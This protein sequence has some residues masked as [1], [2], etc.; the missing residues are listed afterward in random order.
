M[1]ETSYPLTPGLLGPIFAEAGSGERAMRE[2]LFLTFN[3]DLGFFEDRLLG[4]LRETGAAV[5]VVADA[6]VF[7]PDTR[8]VR[9]AGRGYTF[10][11]AHHSAAFHPKLT[12][13][14][15][16]Q[17]ALIG[18][19][20]GNLT[21]GGWHANREILTTIE[22]SRSDG[23][24]RIVTDVIA[25]M[26]E[27][28]QVITIGPLA[29]DGIERTAD[30]LATLAATSKPIDTG[31]RLVHSLGTPIID[32]LPNGE[33]SSLELAAPFHDEHGRALDALIQRYQPSEITV[34]AQSGQA[35]MTPSALQASAG[36]T[37]LH[38]V[39]PDA[40]PA[41]SRYRHGKILTALD[42]DGTVAWSL[43]GSP[44]LTTAALLRT[45]KSTPTGNCELGIVTYD[46][47]RLLPTPTVPVTDVVSLH[48]VLPPSAPSEGAAVGLA[49]GISEARSTIDGLVV[50]L[51]HAT[52]VDLTI[53]VSPYL[54]APE[55]FEP[56]GVIPVGSIQATF[57]GVYD[58]GTRVRAGT[59]M[60]FVADPDLV[61]LRLR[62]SSASGGGGNVTHAELFADPARA[63]KWYQALTALTLAHQQPTTTIGGTS[64]AS[65]P[66]QPGAWKTLEDEADWN[67]YA[68]AAQNMLGLPIFLLA[69]GSAAATIKSTVVGG[70]L[71][72]N[73]P[74]W[75]DR[76]D[77]TAD[78]FE[79]EQTAE[80][81]VDDPTLVPTAPAP[82]SNW[83][84]G[85]Y[86]KWIT[87]LTEIMTQLGPIERIAATQLVLVSTGAGCW[88]GEVGTHGWFDPLIAALRALVREDWPTQLQDQA[89]GLLAVGL[90]RLRL[91]TPGNDRGREAEALRAL[92]SKA[93][94]MMKHVPADTIEAQLPLIDGSRIL[95]AQPDDVLDSIHML[96]VADANEALL[97]RLGRLLPELD[98][99]WSGPAQLHA[100]GRTSNPIQ[101]AGRIFDL[102]EDDRHLAVYVV[103]E[104]DQWALMVSSADRVLLVD[105]RKAPIMYTTH[106]RDGVTTP[107]AL[108][109][110][111]ETRQRTRVSEL[112]FG[113]PGEAEFSVVA[114]V[115]IGQLP[116]SPTVR[117]AL[118]R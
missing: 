117:L 15:G 21:I 118:T 71:P 62:P 101:T 4:K 13:L 59:S 50:V 52:Q 12:V 48:H 116:I 106:R 113:K 41:A 90:Y 36:S 16:P 66:H 31:H 29:R 77:D 89:A 104:K 1:P 44:N 105:G 75:E 49:I 111:A 92:G 67:D 30:T 40:E 86:R 98:V 27:L 91:A 5:T 112:P 28:A 43:T 110:N 6:S 10:G 103:N 114:E 79:E 94:P 18:I 19:G 37:P 80:E 54:G 9:A 78:T 115:P 100:R 76:F 68:D 70:S 17:R 96:T 85:R 42:S 87:Q 83:Q 45:A 58:P 95:A 23:T 74:A 34:L 11:L 22:A 93:A 35:V 64:A 109:S 46:S 7:N 73:A 88:D 97:A 102:A 26:R 60:Q 3:V 38:F 20:S 51:S 24:P 72:S 84:R 108:A 107:L 2:A 57:P 32:Q 69:A 53:E 25:F 39:Q 55:H 33:I 47:R 99:E 82:M 63:E 65:T 61:Q 81:V 14:A 8:S 56:L